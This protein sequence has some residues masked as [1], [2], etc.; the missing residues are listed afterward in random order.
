MNNRGKPIGG[1]GVAYGERPFAGTLVSFA[2]ISTRF[3]GSGAY[4]ARL[5]GARPPPDRQPRVEEGDKL[6]SSPTPG[7]PAVNRGRRY[8]YGPHGWE[9]MCPWPAGWHEP[10]LTKRTC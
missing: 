7:R 3:R 9:R 4:A 1:V 6:R 5:S 8:L 2:S 10:P